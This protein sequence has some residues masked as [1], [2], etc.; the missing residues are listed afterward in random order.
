[1]E[2]QDLERIAEAS[3]DR[4]RLETLPTYLVPEE[5]DEFNDWRQGRRA[6]PAIDESPWLQHIRDTTVGGVRW[7]RVRVLSYPLSDYAEFELH[8]YQGN[9]AAGEDIFVAD[10]GWSTE[11][12]ELTE[13]FWIFDHQTA[14]RM[15]YDD[16]G[17]FVRPE[18]ATDTARY[19]GLRSIAIRHAVA[20]A[21]FLADN[22]PRLIA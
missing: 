5:A 8:G 20:L 13:D 2:L 12:A 15:I 16:E 18:L 22:E 6:L 17:H 19:L 7:W 4:F 9:A 14:I 10:R 21:D 11:L 3:S 1:M